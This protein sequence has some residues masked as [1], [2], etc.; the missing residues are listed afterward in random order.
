VPDS[1]LQRAPSTGPASAYSIEAPCDRF[2]AGLTVAEVA[3]RYRVSPDK[4]RMW[5]KRGE[6][7]AINTAAVRCARP[8]FVVPPEALREFERK[9]AAAPPQKPPRPRRQRAAI[10]F[11]P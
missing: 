7:S 11:F 8:R 3:R 6:L 2:A 9:R 1:H 4:V 5:I 10:D